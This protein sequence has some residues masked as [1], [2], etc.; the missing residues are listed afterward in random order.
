MGRAYSQ[1][2]RERGMAA[3]DSGTG[4]YAAAAIF[5][6]S[7]SYI[8]KALGR[9]K[10]PGETSARPWAGGPKPKL[11]AHDEA[12]C[13]PVTSAA[14]A[15]LA[16]PQ[17]WLTAEHSLKV[18]IGCLWTKATASRALA[19]NKVPARRWARPCGY[20]PSPRGVACL[21]ARSKPGTQSSPSQGC[22]T[23]L[24]RSRR[25]HRPRLG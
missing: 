18:S 22:R 6:V 24:R 7:V 17:A 4:A 11:A 25:R 13:A 1:D 10:K 19:Q 5:R 12:L 16:E 15:T 20:R 8:Y 23:P 9:R 14:D 21:P 3:I 2:L